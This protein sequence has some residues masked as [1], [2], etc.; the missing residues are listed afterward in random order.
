LK[1][2]RFHSIQRYIYWNFEILGEEIRSIFDALAALQIIE[3]GQTGVIESET[4]SS[5]RVKQETS[6]ADCQFVQALITVECIY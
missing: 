3:R 1:Q 6:L 2:E 4:L 5:L